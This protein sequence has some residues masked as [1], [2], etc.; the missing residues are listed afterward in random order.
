MISASNPPDAALP[1]PQ[2]NYSS[3][4]IKVIGFI[5]AVTLAVVA[6]LHSVGMSMKWSETGSHIVGSF[7]YSTLI[8]LPSMFLLRWISVRYTDRYPRGVILMQASALVCTALAGCLA[9]GLVFQLI[10]VRTPDE[11]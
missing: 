8:A 11:Y 5:F 4:I 2:G 7:V 10:G 3:A 9:A 6:L 1:E